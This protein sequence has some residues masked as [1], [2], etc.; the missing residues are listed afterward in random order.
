MLVN[1]VPASTTAS[2]RTELATDVARK[3]PHSPPAQQRPG[4]AKGVTV[5]NQQ[6]DQHHLDPEHPGIQVD[7]EIRAEHQ[8]PTEKGQSQARQHRPVDGPQLG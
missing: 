1:Q 2:H 6:P 7:L 8:Q 5:R 3:R 4:V